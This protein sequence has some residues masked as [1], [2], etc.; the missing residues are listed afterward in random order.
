MT[1]QLNGT[2][3][4]AIIFELDILVHPGASAVL[5]DGAQN[6]LCR[7][8]AENLPVAL[9]SVADEPH[10]RAIFHHVGLARWF[11]WQR[12]IFDDGT[13]CGKPA[14]DLLLRAAWRLGVSLNQ[15]VVVDATIAGVT[16]ARQAGAGGIVA[17]GP[18]IPDQTVPTSLRVPTLDAL[19]ALLQFVA[20]PPINRLALHFVSDKG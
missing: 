7:L 14:A 2:S 10:V 4:K 13:I 9:V 17:V 12:L 19:Q 3:F 20:V 18:P 5:A 16:A 8:Q 11:P 1:F 6:L 15:A